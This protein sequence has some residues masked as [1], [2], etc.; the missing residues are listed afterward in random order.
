MRTQYTQVY[1]KKEHKVHNLS[2][3]TGKMSPVG[4]KLDP[5]LRFFFP[6]SCYRKPFQRLQYVWQ[7]T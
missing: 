4:Y 1:S 5:A 3:N 7:A 2:I 6:T